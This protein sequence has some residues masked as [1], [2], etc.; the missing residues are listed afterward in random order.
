MSFFDIKITKT[1]L[2]IASHIMSL[3]LIRHIRKNEVM[4]KV[5]ATLII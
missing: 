1:Q 4:Y 5:Q 2:L 3:D